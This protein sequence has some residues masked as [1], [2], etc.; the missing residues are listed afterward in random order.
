MLVIDFVAFVV[1]C[2]VS[3]NVIQLLNCGLVTCVMNWGASILN[4]CFALR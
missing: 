3:G 2:V 4:V 1:R